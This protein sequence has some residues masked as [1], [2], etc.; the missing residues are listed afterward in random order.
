MLIGHLECLLK[1][2]RFIG[3]NIICRIWH[4][5]FVVQKASRCL[6]LY[7]QCKRNKENILPYYMPS[8]T[9]C[10]VFSSGFLFSFSFLLFLSSQGDRKVE[11]AVSVF[12]TVHHT[13]PLQIWASRTLYL[14]V[15]CRCCTFIG[16]SISGQIWKSLIR[17]LLKRLAAVEVV[18]CIK[19][20]I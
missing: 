6:L 9:L 16:V 15:K 14:T 12:S 4:Q 11:K 3:K 5:S 7:N 13:Y 20:N 2:N 17:F 19:N 8:A 1:K 10:C 18:L